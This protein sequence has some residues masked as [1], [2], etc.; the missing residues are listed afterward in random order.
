MKKIKAKVEL[1]IQVIMQEEYKA[2]TS[3]QGYLPKGTTYKEIVRVFGEPQ[4]KG[5]GISKNQVKWIGAINGLIFTIY[6][7]KAK[8]SP[9]HNADWHIGG[10][11]EM[12][13]NLV[14]A[15]FKGE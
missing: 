15:Y 4:E 14:N 5:K 9:E 2:G 7:W 10:K 11:Y 13:A 12:V 6:D 8:V 1:E 3:L